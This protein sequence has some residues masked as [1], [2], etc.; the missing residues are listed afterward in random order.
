[1]KARPPRNQAGRLRNL[2]KTRLCFEVSLCLS[3]ACLGKKMTFSMNCKKRR[4]FRTETLT[5]RAVALHAHK[6][7]VECVAVESAQLVL[8][9]CRAKPAALCQIYHQ[10]FQKL[11]HHQQQQLDGRVRPSASTTLQYSRET[12]LRT[13]SWR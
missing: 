5:V 4:V 10:N 1:L 6:V 8:R 11:N 12:D 9:L 13:R 3:R 2:Q 7:A